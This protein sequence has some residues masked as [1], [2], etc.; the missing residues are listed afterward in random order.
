MRSNPHP[1]KI[2]LHG[3][4]RYADL[5]QPAANILVRLE[6]FNGGIAAQMLTDRDGRFRFS[7]LASRQYTLTVRAQGYKDAYQ[8]IDLLTTTSDF[9][10]IDLSPDSPTPYKPKRTLAYIDATVP[11]GARNEFE[12]GEDA[13]T[14]KRP[15]AAIR[16]FENAVQLHAKFFEAELSLGTAYMDLA[17]WDMAEAR[18]RR[19]AEINPRSPNAF[20]ALGELYLHNGRLAEAEKTLRDGLR[21]ENRSWPAHFALA[22]VYWKKADLS[23]TGKQLALTIQ[24]NPDCADAHFLAGDVLTRAGKLADALH[25]FQEYLRLAPKG[26]NVVQA[27]EAIQ[28]LEK[29]LSASSK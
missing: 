26:A 16:H 5:R 11:A 24:L 28:R 9:V 25:M 19:A 14:G 8:T 13:L 17:Q 29:R 23:N 18:L 7:G 10:N 15:Q 20:F 2:E 3:N 22:R 1:I 27:K 21:L 6:N 12:K 4:V